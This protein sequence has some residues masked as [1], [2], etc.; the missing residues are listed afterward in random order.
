LPTQPNLVGPFG[1]I[2]NF[3]STGININ[4]PKPPGVPPA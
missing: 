1:N 3:K 4:L 2:P